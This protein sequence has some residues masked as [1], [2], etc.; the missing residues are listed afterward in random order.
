[1]FMKKI[2]FIYAAFIITIVGSGVTFFIVNTSND[3]SNTIDS[4]TVVNLV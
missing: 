1:M 2:K 3:F 4:N